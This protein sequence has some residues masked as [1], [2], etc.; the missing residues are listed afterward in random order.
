MSLNQCTDQIVL[1]LLPKDR[2]TSVTWLSRDPL[3]SRMAAQAREVGANFGAAATAG[4]YG[5][6]FIGGMADP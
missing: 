2:I 1:A 6:A 5:M 3:T 4:G